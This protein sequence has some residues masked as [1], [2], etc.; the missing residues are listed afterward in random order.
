MKNF[1]LIALAIIGNISVGQNTSY[2]PSD[3]ING[4]WTGIDMYQDSDTYDG[5][6]FFL[7]NKELIII[8]DNSIRI[9]F[10]PY[11][12]SDEFRVNI[13]DSEIKYQL[14]NKTIETDYHFTNEKCDT[15]VFTMHFINKKFVKMYSRVTSTNSIKEIDYATL[16]ELDQYG[17]NPSSISHLFEIDTLHADLYRGFKYLDSLQFK[18]YKFIQFI[19]DKYISINKSVQLELNRG[20]KSVKFFIDG[21]QNEIKISHS[22]GTQSLSIIPVSLCQCD[23]IV[24]PYLTVDW[25]NRIRKDMKENAF[26]YR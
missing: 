13:N 16:D 11:S 9:Y 19:S 15:L 17:F 8:E 4:H 21:V 12:K 2:Q 10:Y 1:L 7:P 23:S 5:S 22:E 25:A 3:M 24:L 18:P 14:N 20:Y 6:T 26:K